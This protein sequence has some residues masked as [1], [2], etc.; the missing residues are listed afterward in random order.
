MAG[1]TKKI[2]KCIKGKNGWISGCGLAVPGKLF[3]PFR[4]Q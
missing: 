4:G 3:L 2:G 1:V